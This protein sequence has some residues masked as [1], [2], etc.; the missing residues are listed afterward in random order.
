MNAAHAAKGLQ[1]RRDSE[2]SKTRLRVWLR[3]LKASRYIEDELRRKLRE[4]CNWTL[5]RFD[6]MAALARTPDGLKMTEISQRL[7]VSNGNV[8]S[9]VDKL[10]EDAL[11]RRVPAPGDRRAHLVQLTAEGETRFAEVAARHEAWVNTLLSGLSAEDAQALAL[12]LGQLPTRP[13]AEQGS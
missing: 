3:L 10:T 5:S 8:T 4:D 9:I 11:A 6:V 7:R 12:H 1:D 2:T 13:E